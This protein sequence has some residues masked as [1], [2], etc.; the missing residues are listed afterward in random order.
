MDGRMTAFQRGAVLLADEMQ[1]P[2]VPLTINGSFNV[3]PRTKDIYWVFW[4][5][6]TLTIHDP[7]APT[8]QGDENV[9]LTMQCS[10]N[11]IESTLCDEYRTNRQ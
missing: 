2:V 7:I 9:R 3:K 1:L 5:P 8:G 4:H 10:K 11:Q 6:M